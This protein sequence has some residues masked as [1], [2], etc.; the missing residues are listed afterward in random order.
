MLSF[1]Y[2][3]LSSVTASQILFDMW[4]FI[5]VLLLCVFIGMVVPEWCWDRAD[6]ASMLKGKVAL[7]ILR[8]WIGWFMCTK[9]FE[10]IWKPHKH[11]GTC[12]CKYLPIM[13]LGQEEKAGSLR[14]QLEKLKTLR[15]RKRPLSL[16]ALFWF[17]T[18]WFY[19]SSKNYGHFAH[20]AKNS[21]FL[22]PLTCWLQSFS[23][24]I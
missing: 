11:E 16:V 19:T 24:V 12:L 5:P 23:S 14:T 15:F 4:E 22:W 9:T 3:C 6:F 2:I 7:S 20:L 1:L 8:A 13:V 10:L 21:F 17:E 18:L